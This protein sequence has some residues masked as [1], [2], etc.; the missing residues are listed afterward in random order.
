MGYICAC[1]ICKKNQIEHPY[2]NNFLLFLKVFTEFLQYCFCFMFCFFGP[3]AF[4][5][6]VPWPGNRT[7]HW[8]AKS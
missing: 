3:K 5:I 6:L 4:G 7:L 1:G 8:K 2:A